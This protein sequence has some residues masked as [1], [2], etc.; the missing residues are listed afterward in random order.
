MMED[1]LAAL[2]RVIVYYKRAPDATINTTTMARS[3]PTTTYSNIPAMRTTG[4][5]QDVGRG[6]VSEFVYTIRK[7]DLGLTVIPDRNDQI[8]DSVASET[9]FLSVVNVESTAD[10]VAWEITAR[11][12]RNEN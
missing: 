11:V 2:G 10:D 8:E 9:F 7:S 5:T 6:A 1:V 3:Y 4:Q 12:K